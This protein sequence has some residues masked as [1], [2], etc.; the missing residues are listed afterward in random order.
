MECL[1][2]DPP[3]KKR[4]IMLSKYK[5]ISDLVLFIKELKIQSP[6]PPPT[7]AK[8]ETTNEGCIC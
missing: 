3:W 5:E 7:P 8:K 4:I 2:R 1:L 6:L